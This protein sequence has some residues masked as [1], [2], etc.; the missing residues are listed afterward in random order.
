[1]SKSELRTVHWNVWAEA[2][3]QLCFRS[4]GSGAKQCSDFEEKMIKSE[5]S[6]GTAEEVLY[7]LCF[8]RE[9]SGAKQRSG[10]SKER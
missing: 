9:G 7:L 4:E 1:M 10:V 5:L 6:T 8:R 2:V 3:Q